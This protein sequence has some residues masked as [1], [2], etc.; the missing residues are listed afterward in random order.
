MK[1]S[2][3]VCTYNREDLIEKCLTHLANQT[4]KDFEL[5]I[6]NNNSTDKTEEICKT[7]IQNHPGENIRLVFEEKK[8]LCAA[9]NCGIKNSTGEWLAYMDDDAF[10]DSKYVENFFTFIASHPQ[11]RV[12]GGKIT[13][14]FE[15][16]RPK[17]LS[18]YI[19]PIVTTLDK[20]N[21]ITFFK[22]RSYP[23]GANMLVHREMF[24][25]Y[26]MFDENIGFKGENRTISSDEKEFFLRFIGKEIQAYYL[27]NVCVEHWV[28]DSRLT[29]EFFVG[30][31]LTIGTSERVRAKNIS[32]Y[33]FITSCIR[34][35]Y[36]WCASIVLWIYYMLTFNPQAANKLI[37][38]RYW[39]SKGLFQ[40]S[41][42]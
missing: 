18:H 39:V 33:E 16:K 19:L 5:V 26:G 29:Q 2:I 13:P 37:A 17:W 38:F 14:Y 41:N 12:C 11:A 25:K 22:H 7:F 35:L 3:I 23:V 6:V 30:Q 9:R 40:K 32:R 28:P 21:K 34:E 31:S 1:L 36:K 15:S 27:P 24:A 10:A 8:G 42:K 4:C 20:G